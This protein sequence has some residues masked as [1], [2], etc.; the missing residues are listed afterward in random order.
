MVPVPERVLGGG[1]GPG[2]VFNTPRTAHRNESDEDAA[3]GESHRFMKEAAHT[4][5]V[6][7]TSSSFVPSSLTKGRSNI[8]I[9][10]G[11]KSKPPA[12]AAT[13][14]MSSAPSVDFF[15]IGYFQNSST[16]FVH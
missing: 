6:L 3:S 4:P 1:N 13:P 12:H 8:S 2:L 9:E 14:K 16:T 15:S 7:S 10:E 5:E 11:G